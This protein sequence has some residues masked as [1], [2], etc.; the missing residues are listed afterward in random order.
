MAGNMWQ[1][2]TN[3]NNSMVAFISDESFAINYPVNP[4][5]TVALIVA[6]DPENMKLYIKSAQANG[7]PNPTKI[8]KM[9]DVT[10]Q[11]ENGDMVSRKEFDSLHQ[12]L[13]KMQQLLE[14]LQKGATK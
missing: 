6:N 1:Q 5:F 14:G 3:N 7:M 11:R 12:Q 4:G 2:P 10:P 8:F 9:E 13:Q